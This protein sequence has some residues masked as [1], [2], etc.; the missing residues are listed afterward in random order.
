MYIYIYIDDE[1]S[2]YHPI[3][4]GVPQGRVLGPL[5]YL[6]YIADVPP[7]QCTLMATFADD[8]AILSSDRDPV[9]ATEKLQ[10]YFHLLKTWLEQWR[11][12]VKTKSAQVKFTIRRDICPPVN[13]HNT[14]MSV[15]K[16]SKIPRDSPRRNTKVEDAHK[17]QTMPTRT[18]A[19][20]H[21]LANKHS[22]TAI[23]RQQT[24][25]I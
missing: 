8:T 15:K 23:P 21:E 1:L 3:R 19:Q 11:I 25:R 9:H 13:L 16:I 5:L 10:H 14:H 2:N 6:I 22:F 24:N 7:T 12:K 17:S 4:T 20:K 18:E